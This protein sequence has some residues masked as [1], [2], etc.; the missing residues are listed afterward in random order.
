[1]ASAGRRYDY[2]VAGHVTAD[3]VRAT[4]AEQVGGSAFYS[5]LQA[6]RLG[7]RTLVVTAGV[8]A[9]VERLLE[10]WRSELDLLVQP[11]PETTRFEATGVGA[12]RRLRV[13]SWAGPLEPPAEPLATR[14]LHVAPVAREVGEL[15]GVTRELTAITPQGLVRRWG[16]DGVVEQAE[17]GPDE[18]PAALDALVVSAE[19]LA[20]CRAAVAAAVARGAVAS[21]TA[22]AGGAEVITRAGRERA[23]AL[24][25][26]EPVEDLGAGDV[27]AAAFF[28]ALASGLGPAPAMQRGQAA[29][30]L[31]LRGG[32]PGA[33]A[34][35][36][37][38]AELA[39]GAGRQSSTK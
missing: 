24:A 34:G 11:A 36:A 27:Y 28:A 13:R 26:V 12:A 25:V 38:I 1:M 37:A 4:G 15:P 10:P 5:G 19:E 18:L 8:P 32:G 33:I 7:L 17:L 6:A 23:P 16:A 22:G 30:L 21:V 3:L 39:A 14:I 31:K 2:V 20:A 29:A 9:E 35:A